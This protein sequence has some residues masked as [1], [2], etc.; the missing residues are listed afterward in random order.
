MMGENLA[1]A[2]IYDIMDT[3]T[4]F[5]VDSHKQSGITTFNKATAVATLAGSTFVSTT[6]KP[7]NKRNNNNN[8]MFMFLF[9]D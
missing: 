1:S 2:S 9:S 7:L 8:A 5:E 4:Q 6:K 3:I